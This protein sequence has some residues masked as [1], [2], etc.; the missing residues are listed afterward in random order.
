MA[1]MPLAAFA[2]ATETIDIRI[3]GGQ[4]ILA[5]ISAG[6]PMPAEDARIK[7]EVAGMIVG[8]HP[9]ESNDP[10]LFWSFAF[11]NKTGQNVVSVTVADV[12]HDPITTLVSDD[13]PKL[14]N[15]SWIGRGDPIAVTKEALPWVYDSRATMKVFRFTVR[16]AD[17]Q[18]SVVHQLAMY[19]V[20]AK[21]AI[22]AQA[23]RLRSGR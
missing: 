15:T 16:Y 14:Q 13:Q 23:E 10:H 12:T 17:D 7:I 20:G 9:R 6:G 8:P 21:Q 2:Q 5:K 1:A 19:P 3:A 18:E 22:R 4:K 11:R